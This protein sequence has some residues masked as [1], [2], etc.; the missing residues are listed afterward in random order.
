M[1]SEDVGWIVAYSILQ[2]LKYILLFW[3]RRYDHNFMRFSSI[4]GEK[5]GAFLRNQCNYPNF[6]LKKLAIFWTKKRHF[7]GQIFRR[8][9]NA[10]NIKY[11]IYTIGPCQ[12]ILKLNAI[13]QFKEIR[14]SKF[15][16]TGSLDRVSS[17]IK[18]LVCNL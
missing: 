11:T 15:T 13:Y 1:D 2:V 10:C 14:N 9:Y 5:I 8:K 3:A 16:E 18:S 12:L 4:S 7:I 17:Q 6:Y